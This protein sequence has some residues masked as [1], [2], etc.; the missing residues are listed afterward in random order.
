MIEVAQIVGQ[1]QEQLEAARCDK[2]AAEIAL[3]E[4][5]LS[6]IPASARRAMSSKVKDYSYESGGRNGLNPVSRKH[7]AGRGVVLVDGFDDKGDGS[8]NRG[9]LYGSR[10]LLM[11]DG[12]LLEQTREGA[13]SHWQGEADEWGAGHSEREDD[14]TLGSSRTLTPAEAV[15]SWHLEDILK[16]LANALEGQAGGAK[17]QRI[18]ELGAEAARMR[19]ILAIL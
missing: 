1:T 13:W 2:E 10:L 6:A 14:E 4:R 16:G 5:I 7:Y 3:F 12:S 9:T 18:E 15:K 17:A 19:A 11:A 8:G